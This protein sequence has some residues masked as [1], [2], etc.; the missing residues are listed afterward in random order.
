M[1]TL[2]G[3]ISNLPQSEKLLP[4]GASTYG[5]HGV[6]WNAQRSSL[7]QKPML[8]FRRRDATEIMGEFDGD[9]TAGIGR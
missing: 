4:R 3:T 8:G 7:F 5:Y 2:V 1:L 9:R 6:L